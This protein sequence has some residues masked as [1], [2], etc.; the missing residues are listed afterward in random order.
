MLLKSSDGS[1]F[2]LYLSGPEEAACGVL[3]IHDWWGVLEYNR[4]WAERLGE[5]GYR[6]ALIDLYDGERARNAEQAGEMMRQLDQD[7]VDGK[8]SA[9]LDYLAQG[10]RR[11][12]ALGWSLGGRQALQAALLDPERVAATVMFYCRMLNN[13]DVL[14]GLGGPVLA[15]YSESETT[16]P[17][18][19]ERFTEAMTEAG[20]AVESH[21]WPAAHGFVNP[22]SSRY[23][24]AASEESWA[25][26]QA[27]LHKHLCPA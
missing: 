21:S 11:V 7:E 19:M 22:E 23:D 27:F 24:A 13:A 8:L 14:A 25:A 2:E 16:W 17:D 3:L 12:A 4:A 18:K 15:L 1:E 20:Q 6:C 26:V 5:L 10:G 9:A